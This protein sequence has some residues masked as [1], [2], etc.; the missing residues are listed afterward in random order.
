MK[1]RR[2]NE[3]RSA[4]ASAD[5]DVLLQLQFGEELARRYEQDHIAIEV[6]AAD[7]QARETRAAELR[8]RIRELEKALSRSITEHADEANGAS[9]G[10]GSTPHQPVAAANP[11]A[12]AG[13]SKRRRLGASSSSAAS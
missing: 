6:R 4:R 9:N 12:A 13:R 2:N 3:P 11:G 7:L 5:S 1:L 10:N 8:A